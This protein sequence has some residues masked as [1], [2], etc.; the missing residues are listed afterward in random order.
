MIKDFEISNNSVVPANASRVML[1]HDEP[2]HT[3][4]TL[5]YKGTADYQD[6]STLSFSKKNEKRKQRNKP[7]SISRTLFQRFPKDKAL[8]RAIAFSITIKS[9]IYCGVARNFTYK[10]LAQLA[11]VSESTARRCIKKL[12][13]EGFAK[14]IG[15]NGKHLQFLPIDK[16]FNNVRLNK[17]F[18]FSSFHD[19]MLG[20]N[21][22]TV[23][24]VQ[25]RKEH[26]VQQA[27]T[28]ND[29]K[30]SERKIKTALKV[31]K[32][33]GLCSASDFSDNGTAQC[34]ICKENNIS[35]STL[36][37]AIRYAE[38]HDIYHRNKRFVA[39]SAFKS[40]LEAMQALRTMKKESD[41]GWVKDIFLEAA[42]KMKKQYNSAK[43]RIFSTKI[44]E[45]VERAF[46]IFNYEICK[47]IISFQTTISYDRHKSKDSVFYYMGDTLSEEYSIVS[48]A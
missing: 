14:R 21:A 2:T 26:I 11:S 40:K 7:T 35:K 29:P 47:W 38:K 19:T 5:S 24:E 42:R 31:T 15:K 41:S 22:A 36:Q 16:R 44:A 10:Q 4:T 13:D 18:D 25:Q 48:H 34:R 33:Q 43:A 8:K 32:R 27:L 28:L 39:I 23:L 3:K 6:G 17:R 20:I 9:Y 37:Q 30:A 45:K 12:L 46:V 1:T